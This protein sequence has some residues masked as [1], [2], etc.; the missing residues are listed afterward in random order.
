MSLSVT[1]TPRLVSS[2]FLPRIGF[3]EELFPESS[4]CLAAS[5]NELLFFFFLRSTTEV[6]EFF[7]TRTPPRLEQGLLA[8]DSVSDF[9]HESPISSLSVL[10]CSS[11]RDLNKTPSAPSSPPRSVSQFLAG[12][13]LRV[14][15]TH[16]RFVLFNQKPSASKKRESEAQRLPSLRRSKAYQERHGKSGI[17]DWG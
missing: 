16:P 3:F 1:N 9:T 11:F 8:W 15:I 7:G 17:K 2:L 10:L 13:F 5:R 6:K 14:I 4:F 12:I